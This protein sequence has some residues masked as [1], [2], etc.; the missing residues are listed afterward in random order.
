MGADDKKN[1]KSFDQLLAGLDDGEV[2]VKL[3]TELE[4]LMKKT[5]DVAMAR[6]QAGDAVAK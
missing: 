1:D 2:V 5:L 4:E 3:D 6:G